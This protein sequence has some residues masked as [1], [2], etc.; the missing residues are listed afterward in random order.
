MDG[1]NFQSGVADGRLTTVARTLRTIVS[2]GFPSIGAVIAV[3]NPNTD[4]AV[5]FHCNRLACCLLQKPMM[6]WNSSAQT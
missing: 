2:H 5:P 4:R 3:G 6:L 1:V